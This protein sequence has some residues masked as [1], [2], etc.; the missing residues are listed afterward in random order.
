MPNGMPD[1]TYVR[2]DIDA[3]PI[4]KRAFYL[5]E[6]EN[7]NAPIGWSRYIP[8]AEDQLAEEALMKAMKGGSDADR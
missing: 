8:K 2:A 7:D 3:N 5:S 1:P 4:W 6:L